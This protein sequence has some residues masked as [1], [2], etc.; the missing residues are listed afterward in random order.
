[1]IY[2]VLGMHKSGTTLISQ[3]LHYS[4]IPMVDE[5]DEATS[6]DRGNQWERESTKALNHQLL[7]SN[8]LFS[9]LASTP[10]AGSAAQDVRR[11]MAELVSRY[12]SS[13]QDWG[14]KDPRSTLSYQEWLPVMPEHRVIAIYRRP[15]EVWSHYWN[16]STQVRRRLMVFRR[17]IACWCEYNM[18]IIKAIQ[19]T[20]VPWIVLSYSRL[21]QSDSDFRRL[22]TF[23]GRP[24]RDERRP[25]MKRSHSS[26]SLIYKLAKKLHTARTGI[27]PT[28][29]LSSME[30]LES[31]K[32]IAATITT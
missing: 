3:M 22:E 24:L 30:E 21:M 25:S 5:V 6:Y 27:D 17:C 18:Q 19:A 14:F 28:S 29:I 7:G 4:G 11:Q 1:M 10:A 9:L 8:G 23:V 13:H 20:T 16:S 15:E 32:P 31:Q 26:P 2:I 12:N